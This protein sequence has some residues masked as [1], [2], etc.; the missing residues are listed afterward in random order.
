MKNIHQA[1]QA[2]LVQFSIYPNIKIWCIFL[3]LSSDKPPEMFDCLSESA[4][5]IG[6]IPPLTSGGL[7]QVPADR[8]EVGEDTVYRCPPNMKFEDDPTQ[9][10]MR[11]TCNAFSLTYSYLGSGPYDPIGPTNVWP[12]CTSSESEFMSYVLLKSVCV[13]VCV[14]VCVKTID[15]YFFCFSPMYLD[16]YL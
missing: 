16:N 1:R 15:R 4:C 5:D 13:C 12:V 2:G 7:Y 9:T 10:E 11:L 3:Y 8:V 6:P 14:F